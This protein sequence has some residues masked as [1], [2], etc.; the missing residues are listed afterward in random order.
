MLLL[1]YYRLQFI[2][3]HYIMIT[4]NIALLFIIIYYC[5]IYVMI[6]I[7]ILLFVITYYWTIYYSLLFNYYISMCYDVP[8]PCCDSG[9][10]GSFIWWLWKNMLE[11]PPV[12]DAGHQIRSPE[13]RRRCTGYIWIHLF[14]ITRHGRVNTQNRWRCTDYIPIYSIH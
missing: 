6:F 7:V 14:Y 10:P 2:T 9:S 5:I 12:R 13:H 11:N 4:L 1:Y 8:L 3:V